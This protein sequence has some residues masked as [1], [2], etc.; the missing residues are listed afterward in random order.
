MQMLEDFNGV[1]QVVEVVPRKQKAPELKGQAE[2]V[3]M[4][5]RL[6]DNLL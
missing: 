6:P 1:N 2:P 3:R 4:L 5:I